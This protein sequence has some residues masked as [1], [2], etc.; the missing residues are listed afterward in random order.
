MNN[1][2]KNRLIVYTKGAENRIRVESKSDKDSSLFKDQYNQ[3]L[4]MVASLLQ[5]GAD[6]KQ[7]AG[8][9]ENV[10]TICGERG[11][12]K[13][14][15]MLSL[16]GMLKEMHKKAYVIPLIDPAHF[17]LDANL[18]SMVLG[19]L[20]NAFQEEKESIFHTAAS[21]EKQ[22][23]KESLYREVYEDMQQLQTLM[24]AAG[25]HKPSRDAHPFDLKDMA[26]SMN[27]RESVKKTISSVLKVFGKD[28]IIVQVDDV[29]LSSIIC[30]IM[31]EQIRKYLTNENV[32]VLISV[33]LD[34]AQDAVSLKYIDDYRKLYFD[35]AK[36]YAD[37][38]AFRYIEKV[39][40][41]SRRIVLYNDVISA[42]ARL[43]VGNSE[44]DVVFA[45]TNL[46]QQKTGYR[47][48]VVKGRSQIVPEILRSYM[49]LYAML[50][51][52]GDDMSL[53]RQSFRKYFT[54][55]WIPEH[56]APKYV[57]WLQ[58]M[59]NLLTVS[60]LN[61]MVAQYLIQ[62]FLDDSDKEIV[63]IKNNKNNKDNVSLGD[64]G[65]VISQVRV[66]TSDNEVV[67]LLFAI[68]TL[69][70]FLLKDTA[71]NSKDEYEL[72]VGGNYFNAYMRFMQPDRSGNQRTI[73]RIDISS[74]RAA[75]KKPTV[76]L[77]TLR[78]AEITAVFMSRPRG[79]K[80]TTINPSYRLDTEKYYEISLANTNVPVFDATSFF[81]NIQHLQESYERF[82]SGLL[83]KASANPE[84]I[85]SLLMLNE[86]V[87]NSE[88]CRIEDYDD[89]LDLSESLA[90][91][92][93]ASV[94]L[95]SSFYEHF[96]DYIVRL[97]NNYVFTLG[98]RVACEI[99]SALDPQEFSKNVFNVVF[100]ERFFD[101]L[102]KKSILKNLS[103]SKVF[104]TEYLLNRVIKVHPELSDNINAVVAIKT[105]INKP[106]NR[107]E[108]ELALNVINQALSKME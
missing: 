19:N 39:F 72:L 69:Y 15:F 51:N 104:P 61:K 101:G 26:A 11:T 102:D 20:A 86:F 49:Q 44:E 75:L 88:S 12:G 18:L 41:L 91:S 80:D 25:D 78:L 48:P 81:Y 38:I 96:K 68:E 5:R 34:Q 55:I 7:Q 107:D 37:E 30:R 50:D 14:S 90:I 9:C 89:V 74:L 6:Y 46:I 92:T 56:V 17:D 29:D 31:M 24:V 54:D 64:V 36:R 93:R 43:K 103:R 58:Q 76:D 82:G 47:F 84:S 108:F 27:L 85:Y 65:Y 28:F 66:I 99:L 45:M 83:E 77:Q 67:T 42:H 1:T 40:P 98:R 22:K 53:N 60:G 97:H 70:R 52:M 73:R 106:M 8:V 100:Q 95:E 16:S 4:N 79:P 23:E 2:E 63:C 105:F 71:Q 94:K 21:F 33:K 59:H 13:T 57:Q 32:I 3:A 10:I 62:A 87:R 35:E